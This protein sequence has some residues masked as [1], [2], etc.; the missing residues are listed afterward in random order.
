MEKLF[1]L[2]NAY[3]L[4]IWLAM[5]FAPRH[6][7]TERA[8]RSTVLLGG[9]AVNYIVALLAALRG[10]G[11]GKMP[12]FSSLE[13]VRQGLST[14]PGALAG[15]NHMLALDLFTGAWIYRQSRRLNA[16]AWVRVPALLF[17]LLAGPVGLLFF[18]IWRALGANKGAALPG[19]T[20][21]QE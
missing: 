6:P 2:A 1:R 14:P 4:P 3:P 9:A 16:P 12:D 5:I 17:T 18:L 10:D 19:F 20:M 13:G 15:W 8:S 11:A 21:G 7:W